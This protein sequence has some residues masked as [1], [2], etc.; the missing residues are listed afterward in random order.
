M[1]LELH[2]WVV[3]PVIPRQKEAAESGERWMVQQIADTVADPQVRRYAA[4]AHVW[5]LGGAHGRACHD[6]PAERSLNQS[7]HGESGRRRLLRAIRHNDGFG[8]FDQHACG[9]A[10]E[11]HTGRARE[12]IFDHAHVRPIAIDGQFRESSLPL[13]LDQRPRAHGSQTIGTGQRYRR[14]NLHDRPGATVSV[15]RHAKQLAAE[16]RVHIDSA[17]GKDGNAIDPRANR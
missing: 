12:P 11:G 1:S 10:D 5:L 13:G 6:R 4:C 15:H 7:G 8:A 2:L 17:I 9:V 16:E 3:A 14:L